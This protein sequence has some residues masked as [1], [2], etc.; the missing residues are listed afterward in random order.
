VIC[1]A[2]YRRV[3]SCAPVVDVA[4]VTLH[5]KPLT[6]IYE[7]LEGPYGIRTTGSTA[8]GIRSLVGTVAHAPLTRRRAPLGPVLQ[9][10]LT[11]QPVDASCGQAKEHGQHARQEGNNS[12]LNYEGRTQS[13]QPV[14]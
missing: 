12:A 2:G 11:R 10:S 7:G 9:L 6:A 5:F 13:G 1:C 8:G 3:T 14:C 4:I